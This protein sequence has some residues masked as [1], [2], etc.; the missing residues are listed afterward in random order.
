MSTCFLWTSRI[1]L[2]RFT[3][4]LIIIVQQ[5]LNCFATFYST[6]NWLLSFLGRREGI[7][8]FTGP[9][10]VVVK[11][12]LQDPCLTFEAIEYWTE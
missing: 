7:Y 3:N 5:L 11:N 12:I 8:S 4:R 10:T 2:T 6:N 1:I 9:E